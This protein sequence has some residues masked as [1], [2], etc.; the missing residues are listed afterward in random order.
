MMSTQHA[1]PTSTACKQSSSRIHSR[2]MAFWRIQQA[3]GCLPS[4]PRR[5]AGVRRATAKL[6][7]LLLFSGAQLRTR[8]CQIK[9]EIISM[10]TQGL[11][12]QYAFL[13]AQLSGYR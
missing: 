2:L 9:S 11:A 6:R 3:Q 7:S 10:L 4:L 5:V 12:H 8:S 13:E 1:P